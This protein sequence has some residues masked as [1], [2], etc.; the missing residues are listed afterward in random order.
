MCS[1]SA[2]L[3][4]GVARSAALQRRGCDCHAARLHLL[5][6]TSLLLFV[7]C[8]A[9]PWHI[10]C[11]PH[12]LSVSGARGADER[13]SSS[14]LFFWRR[15]KTIICIISGVSLILPASNKPGKA[16]NVVRWLANLPASFCFK[17]LCAQVSF[18]RSAHLKQSVLLPGLVACKVSKS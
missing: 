16:N 2:S 13:H 7:R 18:S 14:T 8:L 6:R 17:I 5:Q 15:Q 11:A 10:C 9:A 12:L 3:S 4:R 1:L